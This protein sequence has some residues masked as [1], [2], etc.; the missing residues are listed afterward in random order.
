[1]DEGH[2]V[3][4]HPAQS[5]P[6]FLDQIA[7]VRGHLEAV[8]DLPE[9]DQ[10]KLTRRLPAA[11]FE[12]FNAALA[13]F[14]RIIDFLLAYDKTNERVQCKKGCSNCCIDLVRGISTP[15]V[16]NIYHHVRT[17]PDAKAIFEYHRESAE[18]F[19]A[20]LRSKLRPGEREFCGD[21]ARVI[22]AHREFNLRNRPCGFLDQRTGCCRIYPVRPIACRYFFSLD[23][24]EYCTPTHA[25]YFNRDIRTVHLPPEVHDVLLD[26]GRKL[27]LHALNYLSGAFCQFASEVMHAR[28]IT[29]EGSPGA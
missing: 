10:F 5:E 12:H 19:M 4:P 20:I 14:D 1:M 6:Y 9:L 23:P 7:C 3:Q 21:D 2:V 22:E 29:V 28:P 16:I 17:W 26:I 13:A 24:A 8:R 25:K 27:D 11:F 18:I 15:E